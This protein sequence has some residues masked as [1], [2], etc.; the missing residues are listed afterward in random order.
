VL[1]VMVATGAQVRLFRRGAARPIGVRWAAPIVCAGSVQAVAQMCLRHRWNQVLSKARK[2]APEQHRRGAQHHRGGTRTC[3]PEPTAGGGSKR[4]PQGGTT[5]QGGGAPG[6]H[7]TAG[8][9]STQGGRSHPPTLPPP[10][11]LSCSKGGTRC[12]DWRW[13]ETSRSCAYPVAARARRY[14]PG[15]HAPVARY[16]RG[17]ADIPAEI[18]AGAS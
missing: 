18:P 6:G 4:P 8:G 9:T 14:I 11:V 1:V 5:Q 7:N 13:K 3:G 16:Q 2:R 12:K 17:A 15:L 10:R